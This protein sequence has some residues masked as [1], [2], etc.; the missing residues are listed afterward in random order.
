MPAISETREQPIAGIGLQPI[1][2]GMLAAV[3]GSAST[4]ALVLAALTATGA[5]AQQ[6]GSGLFAMCIAVGVL[7]AVLS[8][9]SRMPVSIA[10]TTPGAAFLV[11]IGTPAGGFPSVAGAFLVTALLIVLSGLIRPLARAIAAIPAPIANAMLAGMLLTL[12]LAPFE[13]VGQV[14]LL[15]LPILFAWALGLRFARRYAVPIAVAVTG[16][17][18]ALTT[19]LPPGALGGWP[20]LVPVMPSFTLDAI[21]RISLPLFIVTM[22]SQNLPGLA[23]MQA[24]GYR[25]KP[26]PIFVATGFGSAVTAIFGGLTVNLAAITAAITA[27]P[28]AH[29]DPAAR[30]VAPIAAGGTYIVLGAG[31]SLAAAFVAA[32]PPILIQAVAGL[33][34]LSSLAAAL[35]AALADEEAR[36]PVILTFVATASGVTVLGIGAPFWGLVGGIALTLILRGRLRRQPDPTAR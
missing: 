28:E 3:V 27:G 9:R 25:P 15:A 17:V 24:N 2:A 16:L 23:V 36:L 20:T 35:S 10:W 26:G 31:A 18:L 6:A 13:A 7:N 34:L 8:W 14:P 21:L 19:R 22:A 12:C 11:T 5:S 4:F 33:A 32:S 29:P 30:W 1:V